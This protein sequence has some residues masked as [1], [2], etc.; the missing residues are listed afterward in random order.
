MEVTDHPRR[1]TGR[2]V[3]SPLV[4]NRPF[5]I[6]AQE[7]DGLQGTYLVLASGRLLWTKVIVHGRPDDF[8]EAKP[9]SACDGPTLNL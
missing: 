5:F 7:D 9:V 8:M 6:S 1:G 2:G 4:A 3:V